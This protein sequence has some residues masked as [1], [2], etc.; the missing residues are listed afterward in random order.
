MFLDRVIKFGETLG[1]TLG[2]KVLLTEK[3][4]IVK[5]GS[6]RSPLEMSCSKLQCDPYLIS[7]ARSYTELT[8]LVR[9]G[10]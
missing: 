5:R 10:R 4:K 1:E 2:D 3:A 8:T 7:V 9:F 6:Q